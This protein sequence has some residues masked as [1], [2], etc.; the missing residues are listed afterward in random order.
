PGSLAGASAN[1]AKFTAVAGK[2]YLTI[3]GSVTANGFVATAMDTGFE[4]GEIQFQPS[5]GLYHQWDVDLYTDRIRF[6]SNGGDKF[7]VTQSAYAGIGT[8]APGWP[9]EVSSGTAAT[10][11]NAQITATGSSGSASRSAGY[12]V[13]IDATNLWQMLNDNAVSSGGHRQNSLYFQFNGSPTNRYL[14]IA[15]TGNVYAKNNLCFGDPNTS[16]NCRNTWAGMGGPASSLDAVLAVG[17]TSARSAGLGSTT[18]PAGTMLV[19]NAQSGAIVDQPVLSPITAF[20][21]DGLAAFANSTNAALYARQDSSGTSSYAGYFSS[22]YASGTAGALVARAGRAFDSP[23]GDPGNIEGIGFVA[24][25]QYYNTSGP[26]LGLSWSRAAVFKGDLRVYQRFGLTDPAADTPGNYIGNVLSI[27]TN[28]ASSADGNLTGFP[29]HVNNLNPNGYAA[30]FEGAGLIVGAPANCSGAC[31]FPRA[32]LDVRNTYTSGSN[33]SSTGIMV[34]GGTGGIGLYASGGSEAVRASGASL[35]AG[36]FIGT[37][38]FEGAGGNSLNFTIKRSAQAFEQK[39]V[40][41]T[42]LNKSPSVTCD[43]ACGST[44]GGGKCVMAW[45]HI[46]GGGSIDGTVPPYGDRALEVGCGF[47]SGSLTTFGA[48]APG[49]NQAYEVLRCLCK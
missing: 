24:Q 12:N 27:N 6:R 31:S 38:L 45:R 3:P 39:P 25:H 49:N 42:Q 10:T 19:H 48:P 44:A 16:T 41:W 15:P 22:Q 4:G 9:L 29:L 14:A 35:Y 23:P 34:T 30:W 47:A 37:S 21:G 13:R 40:T 36:K 17:N 26:Q 8:N 20:A 28:I 1:F 5:S 18:V 43:T 11:A 33:I 46:T 7:T 2:A 32:T